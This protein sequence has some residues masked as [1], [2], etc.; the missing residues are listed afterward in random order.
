MIRTM[1]KSKIHRATVTDAD[2]EYGTD[3]MFDCALPGFSKQQCFYERFR[4]IVCSRRT[5]V[6]CRRSVTPAFHNRRSCAAGRKF[7][8]EHTQ[9]CFVN[10][11]YCSTLGYPRFHRESGPAPRNES[12]A[13]LNHVGI[14]E[15]NQT[16]A[17]HAAHSAAHAV[18]NDRLVF[19]R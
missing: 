7:E 19:V 11:L 18:N 15:G 9:R 1:L 5:I 16:L 13:Q 10:L 14:A 3:Y 4:P 12:P 6:F 8:R 2:L 17:G